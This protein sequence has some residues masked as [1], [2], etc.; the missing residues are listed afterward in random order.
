M[1]QQDVSLQSTP[2]D[3]VSSL[4][5]SRNNQF[6]AATAWNG[7]LSVWDISKPAA[8]VFNLPQVQTPIFSAAWMGDQSI[9]FAGGADPYLYQV[10]LS[11]GKK[12]PLGKVLNNHYFFFKIFWISDFLAPTPYSKSLCCQRFR[13]CSY[14]ILG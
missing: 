8:P 3:T 10:T 14:W 12:T 2:N 6:L 4:S 9:A 11:S 13:L 7:T 1:A 5:F